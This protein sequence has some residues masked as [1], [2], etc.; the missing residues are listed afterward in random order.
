[1]RLPKFNRIELEPSSFVTRGT[2]RC[3]PDGGFAEMMLKNKNINL[4]FNIIIII[5]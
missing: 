1:M 5:L 4:D 3:L 2:I